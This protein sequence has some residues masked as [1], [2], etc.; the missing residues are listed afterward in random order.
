MFIEIG[1]TFVVDMAIYYKVDIDMC[2]K[3][4]L[5]SQSRHL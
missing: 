1:I 5:Y 4:L 3:Y 2:I